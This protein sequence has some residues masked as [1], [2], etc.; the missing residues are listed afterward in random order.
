[1]DL[2]YRKE[3]L[4][5]VDVFFNA[6][7]NWQD[8]VLFKQTEKHEKLLHRSKMG[9]S[10]SQFSASQRCDKQTH[11]IETFRE[12]QLHFEQLNSD[13]VAEA[14]INGKLLLNMRLTSVDLDCTI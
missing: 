2:T 13:L 1:M 5:G 14:K 10:C 12:M 9:L 3:A 11:L 7:K 4:E 6:C 8:K